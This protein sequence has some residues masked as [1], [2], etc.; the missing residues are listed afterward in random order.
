[1]AWG[2]L[3]FEFVS[4]ISAAPKSYWSV[5]QR[6]SKKRKEPWSGNRLWY[7]G[8]NR[9]LLSRGGTQRTD[10]W[11]FLKDRLSSWLWSNSINQS[12]SIDF[13]SAQY[14][15]AEEGLIIKQS[16]CTVLN[17]FASTGIVV[18]MHRTES[19]GMINKWLSEHAL[20]EFGMKQYIQIL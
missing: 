11:I 3:V 14:T 6:A 1:M 15:K 17:F 8:Y 4:E 5:R 18:L 16:W 20:I 7:R 13:L 9:H 10:F 12:W 19:T 2:C